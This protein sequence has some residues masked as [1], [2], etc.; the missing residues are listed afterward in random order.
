M[1]FNIIKKLGVLFSL[2]A[3]Q[4]NVYAINHIAAQTPTAIIP[5]P[6]LGLFKMFAGLFV[7]IGCMLLLAWFIK[8]LGLA[9]HHQTTIAKVI[10]SVS[11]GSRERVVV[12][13]IADRWIVVGVAPG[14]V[15][16]IAT[17]D[18]VSVS[19]NPITTADTASVNAVLNPIANSP[20]MTAVQ[21]F[22]KPHQQT[23]SAEKSKSNYR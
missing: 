7:V 11:V 21:K 10:S 8:R 13:E 14:R 20:W 12:L 5:S 6:S 1:S 2:E 15:N 23:T 22:L 16:A 4:A 17:L 9:N 18:N 3:Y 19:I